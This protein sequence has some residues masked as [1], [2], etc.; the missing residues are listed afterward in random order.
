MVR[1]ALS[2]LALAFALTSCIFLQDDFEAGAHCGFAGTTA[3]AACMR[4]S[5][6]STID[7]CCDDR[8]CR[9]PSFGNAQPLEALDACGNGPSTACA[10]KISKISSGISASETMFA[11]MKSSCRDT[12]LA[13]A[14]VP[15]SCDGP[16][17]S[18][19]SCAGCIYRQ[20]GNELDT[21]C[22]DDQC[23]RSSTYVQSGTFDLLDACTSEDAPGCVYYA[24]RA[25]TSGS[26]GVVAGCIKASCGAACFGNYRPH[27]SCQLRESGRYC[28]CQ[29]A[30]ASSGNECSTATVKGPC[31]VGQRGCQCG[32]YRCTSSSRECT[33]GFDGDPD[34]NLDVCEIA[35]G[36]KG[37]CCLRLEDTSVTCTCMPSST[38]CLTSTDVIVKSCALA[39]V[40]AALTP[41]ER[42]VTTCSQ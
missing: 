24:K 41:A 1:R 26:E 42:W 35:T 21:C 25:S 12:C 36:S 2:V 34:A 40:Q 17:E 27:Q 22:S 7:A 13:G 16:R 3:C 29:D 14:K 32:A 39:D 11:C 30:L 37:V 19:T 33:C 6:Q 10:D 4:T 5:C 31:I 18:D 23:N 38:S 9:S 8:S 15:F 28:S 20:C